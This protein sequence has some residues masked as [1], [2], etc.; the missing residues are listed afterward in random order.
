MPDTAENDLNHDLEQRREAVLQALKPLRP[1]LERQGHVAAKRLA[2]GVGVF[3]LRFRTPAEDAPRRRVRHS[4]N[5]GDDFLLAERVRR[6][7]RSWRWARR[8]KAFEAQEQRLFG[9]IASKSF[10][11]M[12]P[13]QGWADTLGAQT[14]D[15]VGSP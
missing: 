3:V 11:A 2:P 6:L 14:A 9:V 12:S 8:W 7:L 5:L 13:Q 15:A 4:I 1:I 10:D